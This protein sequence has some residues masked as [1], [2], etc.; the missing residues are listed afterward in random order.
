MN[1]CYRADPLETRRKIE[2]SRKSERHS[3]KETGD[4]KC[5]LHSLDR[6]MCL[7]VEQ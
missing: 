5:G 3:E 1:R 2:C 6:S 7:E 4:G